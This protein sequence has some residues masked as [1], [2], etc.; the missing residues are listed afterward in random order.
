MH[1][2]ETTEVTELALEITRVR[3]CNL[4]QVSGGGGVFIDPFGR[5]GNQAN[6]DRGCAIDPNG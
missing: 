4:D 1:K 3:E 5:D 2:D 6:I